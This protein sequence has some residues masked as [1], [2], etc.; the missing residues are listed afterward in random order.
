VSDQ[1]PSDTGRYITVLPCT[2]TIK[3]T[4][5]DLAPFLAEIDRSKLTAAQ[6]L[7]LSVLLG[8]EMVL[9][10]AL[11]DYLLDQGHEYATE[12]YEKGKRDAVWEHYHPELT[13]GIS[14]STNPPGDTP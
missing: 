13:S 10:Q 5:D 6:Q 1:Q 14:S 11:A 8:D 2:V 12:C 7:A 4:L 3:Y 9:P